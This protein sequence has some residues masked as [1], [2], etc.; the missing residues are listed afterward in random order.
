MGQAS[1]FPWNNTYSKMEKLRKYKVRKYGLRFENQYTYSSKD[2][3]GIIMIMFGIFRGEPLLAIL[4]MI[5]LSLD[6]VKIV[7]EMEWKN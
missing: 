3:V 4:G 2:I 7:E 6:H 5:L 1:K